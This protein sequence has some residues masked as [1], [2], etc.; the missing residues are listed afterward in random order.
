MILD[1]PT[2]SLDPQAEADL[3]G[4]SG[5]CSRALRCCSSRTASPMSARRTG[6]TFMDAGRVIE[7]GDHEALLARDG[8]YARLFPT[9]RPR[10]T[11]DA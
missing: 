6:S 5:S 7:Q 8:T 4:R 10:R 11:Q 3:F 2:A 1:E 9:S